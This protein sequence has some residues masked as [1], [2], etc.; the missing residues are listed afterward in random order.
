LNGSANILRKV[1]SNLS[2]DLGLLG[3]G[4]WRPY[5]EL[6][7]GCYLSLLCPKNLSPFR[8]ESVKKR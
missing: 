1:A 7:F 3:R 4:A 8:A 6:D 5:R 2:I